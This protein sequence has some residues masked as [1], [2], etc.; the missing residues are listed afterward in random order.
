MIS[1]SL[2]LL[3]YF[4]LFSVLPVVDDQLS[5]LCGEGS[6]SKMYFSH[7]KEAT[8]TDIVPP[9]ILEKDIFSVLN[10]LLLYFMYFHLFQST[11]ETS[12][13]DEAVARGEWWLLAPVPFIN[14]A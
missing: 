7:L 13:S 9:Y 8:K 6:D 12:L 10:R 14:I 1:D 4:F 11:R 5:A 2:G 3:R